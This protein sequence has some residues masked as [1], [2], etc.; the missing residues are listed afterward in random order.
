MT[1]WNWLCGLWSV[2]DA[3]RAALAIANS[4]L[5]KTACF[6]ENPNFGRIAA[7][8]GAS[9]IEM[10]ERSLDIRVGGLH[11]KEVFVRVAIGCGRESAVVYTCDLTPEYIKINAEYN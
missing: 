7:A 6:G 10:K 2:S 8:V 5:F 1:R 3:R 9:G 4:A 11:S